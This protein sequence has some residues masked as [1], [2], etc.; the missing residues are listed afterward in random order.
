[1]E[2]TKVYTAQYLKQLIQNPQGKLLTQ[3]KLTRCGYPYARVSFADKKSNYILLLV[4][5]AFC[6]KNSPGDVVWHIDR[7]TLNNHADNLE[8]ITRKE[9]RQRRAL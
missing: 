2:S 5:H 4:A 3:H 7:N 6:I 1:M 9:S 8:W